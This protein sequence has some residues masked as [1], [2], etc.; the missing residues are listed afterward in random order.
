MRISLAESA[1]IL[2]QKDID[3][4]ETMVIV[5]RETADAQVVKSQVEQEEVLV[6]K[7]YAEAQAV[8]AEVEDDLAAA[9]PEM[10]KAKAAVASL[11]ASSIVEMAALSKPSPALQLVV[12]PIMLLLGQKKDWA[13]AQQQMRKTQPF[14]KSL[15]E[16][17][18]STIKESLI[19]KIRKEY[20]AKPEFNV[21]DM[22][23][24]SQPCGA[25]C[26]WVIALASYQVVYKKIV[27]KKQKLAIVSKEAADAKAILDE[28]L[29]GVRAA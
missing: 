27:P 23:R 15:K 7:Q 28:K 9:Q 16:F 18:V 14:L 12:E 20:L 8:K 19:T 29:A 24:L 22:T 4:A 21:K 1:P 11:E 3:L 10:D 6:S 13:T 25:M 17:D 2:A 26:T 5:E